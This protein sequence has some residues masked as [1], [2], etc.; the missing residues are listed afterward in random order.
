MRTSRSPRRTHRGSGSIVG[1]TSSRA[2]SHLAVDVESS[3]PSTAPGRSSW[4]G[5]ARSRRRPCAARRSCRRPD[6]VTFQVTRCLYEH[7]T[8]GPRAARRSLRARA[9]SGGSRAAAIKLAVAAVAEPESTPAASQC[10]IVHDRVRHRSGPRSRPTARTTVVDPAAQHERR[11]PA[12]PSRMS[13]SGSCRRRTRIGPSISSS[14]KNTICSR[15]QA[16]PQVTGTGADEGHGAHDHITRSRTGSQQPSRPD[17]TTKDPARRRDLRPA[18]RT[19]SSMVSTRGIDVTGSVDEQ[20]RFKGTRGATL[21][22]IHGDAS[23]SLFDLR[24]HT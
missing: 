20:K 2:R 15:H 22:M 18:D 11:A 17:S 24:R 5:G 16:A 12:R 14:G 23:G 9:G 10:Q 21:H 7:S 6:R 3:R 8:T 1:T 4:T 19:S 13:R